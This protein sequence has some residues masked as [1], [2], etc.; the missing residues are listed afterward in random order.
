MPLDTKKELGI[1]H[2]RLHGLELPGW[3]W[4]GGLRLLSLPLEHDVTNAGFL[5][6]C[7]EGK[8]AYI[9]DTAYC[10]YLIPGL[11][12]LAVECNFDEE[13]LMSSGLSV[14]Q[15]KRVM[16]TH[17]GLAGVLEFLKAND[18]DSLQEIHLLHLSDSNSHEGRIREAIK[19]AVPKSCKVFI[20]KY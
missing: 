3:F 8:A 4:I 17:F 18:L 16:R 12:L 10:R 14:E 19:K 2:H 6:T 15:R 13:S 5:V 9:T 7:E 11:N 1:L 20:A